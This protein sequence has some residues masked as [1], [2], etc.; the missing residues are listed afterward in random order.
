MVDMIFVC[1][2]AGPQISCFPPNNFTTKQAAYVDTY[3]WD[4]LMHHEFD[5][6]GNFEERSLWVH[7]VSVCVLILLVKDDPRCYFPKRIKRRR[8]PE[9]WE[10]GL[11]T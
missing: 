7:K 9:M 8:E 11:P 6:D 1:F 4:S 3:C 2:P 10:E 5:T